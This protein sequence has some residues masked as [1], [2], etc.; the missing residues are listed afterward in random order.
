MESSRNRH[1]FSAVIDLKKF[2]RKSRRRLFAGFVFSVL[3]HLGIGVFIQF[4]LPVP[5]TATIMEEP[6]RRMKVDIIEIP[7]SGVEAGDPAAPFRTIII[8]EGR[9]PVFKR[10]TVDV[11]ELFSR[12]DIK[13]NEYSG[14]IKRRMQESSQKYAESLSSSKDAGV[15]ST[16][17]VSIPLPRFF[18]P[19]TG[20][21]RAEIIIPRGDKR[22]VQ[23]YLQIPFVW[24]GPINLPDTL[25]LNRVRHL[26]RAMNRY[27]NITARAVLPG[28]NLESRRRGDMFQKYP[29]DIVPVKTEIK[30][31]KGSF[32]LIYIPLEYPLNLN[33]EQITTLA[34]HVG[35]GGLL[36]FDNIAR[37]DD[38]DLIGKSVRET[39]RKYIG[40]RWSS[41]RLP[42]NHILYHCFFDFAEGAPPDITGRTVPGASGND[43]IGFFNNTNLEAVYCP[44][45]YGRLWAD[46]T[47]EAHCKMGVNMVVYGLTRYSE[48]YTPET[49]E[50]E[51]MAKQFH[52]TW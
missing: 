11:Q 3:F 36:V 29:I 33:D 27:S 16:P 45:G 35:D 19:D 51:Y 15:S 44:Q 46:P 9:L 12:G 21:H 42:K 30:K 5:E 40:W 18:I 23:G 8:P 24:G 32:P 52:K 34:W 14:Y 20:E 22:A 25:Y 38:L 26:A 28:I 31:D 4:R 7:A 39:M 48:W 17:R 43:L 6:Y 50:T 10:P 2:E 13:G 49:G 47:N 41:K 1:G 37:E